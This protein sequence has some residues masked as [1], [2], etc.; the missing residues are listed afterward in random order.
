[1]RLSTAQQPSKDSLSAQPEQPLPLIPSCTSL[2]HSGLVWLLWAPPFIPGFSSGVPSTQGLTL[3]THGYVPIPCTRPEI[4][5]AF[6]P[7]LNFQDFCRRSSPFYSRGNWPS[8]QNS[9]MLPMALKQKTQDWL[10][11]GLGVLNINW[12]S[13]EKGPGGTSLTFHVNLCF[14]K[15]VAI[16]RKRTAPRIPTDI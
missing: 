8:C 11:S 7:S 4:H 13:K 6:S 15:P 1:M 2:I 14:L 9:P 12:T 5:I 16:P 3:L 10:T